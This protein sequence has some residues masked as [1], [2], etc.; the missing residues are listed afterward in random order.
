MVVPSLQPN[1][2]SDASVLLL[3]RVGQRFCLC[4]VSLHGPFGEDVFA[5]L[6]GW[7]KRPGVS[8]DADAAHDQIDVGVVGYICSCQ[9]ITKRL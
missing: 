9:H 7:N 8:I 1:D 2:M 5:S 6:D 3:R 4:Q